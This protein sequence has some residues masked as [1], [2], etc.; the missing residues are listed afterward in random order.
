[1]KIRTIIADDQ[2]LAR[3]SLRRMLQHEPD[4][5]VVA[6]AK[7]GR[8]AVE[9]I[10]RLKPDLVFLDVEMPGLDGFGVISQINYSPLPA[11]IF[12]SGNEEFAL[13]AFEVNAVDYLL[14]P[15]KAERLQTAVHRARELL[16]RGF[17]P[18]AFPQANHEAPRK[19]HR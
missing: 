6:L 8:E 5:E 13:R 14:K 15:C 11:V 1:M 12:V 18:L 19:H 16:R 2:L 17:V 3:E 4:I 9:A 10:N 7:G